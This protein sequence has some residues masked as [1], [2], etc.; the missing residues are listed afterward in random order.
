MK[1]KI[2]R[3][4]KEEFLALIPPTLYFFIAL[5]V[6]ALVR[7]LMTKG[8]GITPLSSVAIAVAALILGKAVLIAD[9]L[10]VINRYPDKPLFYNIAWKTTIYLL[11]ATVIHYM[12]RL[13][14]YWRQAGGLVAG[15]HKL[16]AEMVW[17][18][19]WG[20][21]IVLLL[22][23]VAYCTTRELLRVLGSDRMRRLFFGPLPLPVL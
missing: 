23:I 19:F 8:M 14:E 9:L 12:E 18:Q 3:I 4:I 6:V 20:I 16:L 1:S 2:T 15:N 10:P 22:L 7:A 5:H 17:P 13:V 21:Q 11:L